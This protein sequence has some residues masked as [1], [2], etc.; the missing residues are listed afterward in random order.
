MRRPPLRGRRRLIEAADWVVWQ[1]TGNEMRNSCTAGYKAIWSKRDG[2]PAPAFFAALD[3]RFERIVDEKMARDIVPIGERAGGLSAEAAAWTGPAAWHAVAVANVD[4]HVS[5][6]AVGVTAPGT[7]VAIMGTSTCH[8]VLGDEPDRRDVRR[9]RGRRGPRPLRLRGRPVGGRRHLRLVRRAPAS[10]RRTTRRPRR[11]ARA[12]TRSSS[13]RQRRLRPGEIGPA[14]ARLVER[15]PVGAGRCRP[16]RP[17]RRET[18]AT[19]RRTS[20][21]P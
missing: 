21:V 1:L 10:R 11:R 14:R 3:P 13:S 20:I 2:F 6:P 18:L 19:R 5:A 9:R 12:S 7:L 15:Q 17:A 16:D 4:A 8:V